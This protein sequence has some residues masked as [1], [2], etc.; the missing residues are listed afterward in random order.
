MAL[1]C[2][3]AGA[4]PAGAIVYFHGRTWYLEGQLFREGPSGTQIS[5]FATG[6]IPGHSYKLFSSPFVPARDHEL[7]GYSLTEVN[8]NVRVATPNGFIGTTTGPVTGEPGDHMICF[9][10]LDIQTDIAHPEG[11]YWVTMYLWFSIL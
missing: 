8:P 4:M 7:C 9:V 11:R 10:D 2:V 1:T 3:L 6:A 5:A